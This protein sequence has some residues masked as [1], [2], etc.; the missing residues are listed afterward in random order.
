VSN[1][2]SRPAQLRTR[3]PTDDAALPGDPPEYDRR[4]RGES[5]ESG[6]AEGT[7]IHHAPAR[8]IGLL[9]ITMIEPPFRAL[10]VAPARGAHA[11]AAT[12]R[13]A[14]GRAVRVSP[15]ARGANPE[16]PGTR[17]TGPH[18]KCRLHEAAAR[19]AR[20]RRSAAPSWRMETTDSAC[21]SLESVTRAWRSRSRSS[22]IAPPRQPYRDR[23]ARRRSLRSPTHLRPS[24]DSRSVLR[25]LLIEERMWRNGPLDDLRSCSSPEMVHFWRVTVGQF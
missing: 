9:V 8:A 4:H 2:P 13:P 10:L 22:R 6:G 21:R 15:I 19:R 18:P 23:T 1:R 24:P 20:P 3:P 16:R 12:D 17:P 11:R 25:V 5:A 14:G 7:L